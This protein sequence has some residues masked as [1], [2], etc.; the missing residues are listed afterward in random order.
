M[1]PNTRGG[2]KNRTALEWAVYSK[3]EAV[4]RQFLNAGANVD[5]DAIEQAKNVKQANIL[6][7]LIAA[8][9]KRE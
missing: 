6:N 2:K 7:L 3:N 1:N 5:A 4:V 9:A 8:K